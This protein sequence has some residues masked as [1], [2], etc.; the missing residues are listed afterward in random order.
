MSTLVLIDDCL[1]PLAEAKIGVNDR[2]FLFGD[3]VYEVIATRTGKA[4]F[5]ADHLQRLRQSAAGIYLE[6][7]WDHHW[8][9]QRIRQ[10]LDALQLDAAYVRIVVSRG[11]GGF[12]IALSSLTTGPQAV[13]VFKAAPDYSGRFAEQGFKLAVPST[14]RNAPQS[15]N[16][17]FKTGNYLNNILCL[18]E[19]RRQGADDALILALD[20]CV[21]ELSTSNFFIVKDGALWT[22]PLELGILDGITRRYLIQV[23]ESIGIDCHCEPFGLDSVWQADEAFVSSSV[24]GAMPV[25]QIDQHLFPAG[26]GPIT[27]RLNQAYWDY[28]DAHLDAY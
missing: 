25:C 15:L 22:A 4:Y 3:S 27:Q 17:A 7:P 23:A 24:K 8:F 19:A 26:Y 9:E 14:R 10:G 12:D 28:V 16:P 13:F 18:E 11:A 5:T 6:I 20:G 2:S 21:T 1:M